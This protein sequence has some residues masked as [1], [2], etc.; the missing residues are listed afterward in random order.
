MK[1]NLLGLFLFASLA[2]ANIGVVKTPFALKMNQKTFSDI[3]FHSV[4][5]NSLKGSL[6]LPLSDFAV[7]DPFSVR[8]SGIQLSLN[9]LFD[10]PEQKNSAWSFETKK[11]SAALTVQKIDATQIIR[12]VND[13]NEMEIRLDGV[14]TNIRLELA[15]GLTE[16][17]GS[18]K[19]SQ[20]NSIPQLELIKFQANWIPGS[21]KIVSMDC[22][23]PRGFDQVIRQAAGEKLQT[24]NPFLPEIQ[25]QIQAVL[26]A[27]LKDPIAMQ[28]EIDSNPRI[29]LQIRSEPFR[30]P[31]QSQMIVQ[32]MAQFQFY[33]PEN[34]DCDA[35]IRGSVKNEATESLAL[36]FEAIT[37]LAKC[38][39]KAG[40]MRS[41]IPSNQVPAFVE[42]RASAQTVR[43]VWPDLNSF[44]AKAIF[45]FVF[46]GNGD[47]SISDPKRTGKNTF[48]ANL[49]YPLKLKI[50]APKENKYLPYLAFT[51][52]LEGKAKFALQSGELRIVPERISQLHH[53]WD[54]EYL[55]RFP[56][57]QKLLT[58]KIQPKINELAQT[59][60]IRFRLPSFYAG[61]L[62]FS[63]QEGDLRGNIFE[64][65]FSTSK[66]KISN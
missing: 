29:R 2:Q 13:G 18:I 36:P 4:V 16:A 58:D 42:F 34:R 64:M 27:G 59:Q 55:A 50:F 7:N 48:S 38:A 8:V 12:V 37:A 51:S 6:S 43:Y 41:T 10:T 21:W 1:L 47:L 56:T 35:E 32:G 31:N 57:D 63:P 23:G 54:E 30:A 46:G 20:A 15:E 40:M 19:L 52:S 25:S 62:K 17:S 53:Q 39:Q 60:G 24:I 45:P 65:K 26:N 44:S 33:L 22:Q 14:C 28:F 5:E 9:Y 49:N 3:F 61:G 11:L 66:G